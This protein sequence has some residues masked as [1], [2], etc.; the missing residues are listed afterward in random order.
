MPI[1]TIEWVK[2]AIVTGWV[3]LFGGSAYY[4]YLVSKGQKFLM[5]M[6]LI[7]LFLA[8]FIGY[9]TGQFIWDDV[10]FRDWI[11]AISWFTSFP[12]LSL[13]EKKWSALVAKYIWIK[14]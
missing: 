3:G 1:N 8:F 7:N 12:L 9:I 5:S 6:F 13:L 11:L 14:E 4:L 2:E 10:A